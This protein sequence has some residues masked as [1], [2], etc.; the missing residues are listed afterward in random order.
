MYRWALYLLGR[1]S[2]PKVAYPSRAVDS[3]GG[4]GEFTVLA[5][6]STQVTLFRTNGG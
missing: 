3:L 5:D 4:G 2:E 1:P 6:F